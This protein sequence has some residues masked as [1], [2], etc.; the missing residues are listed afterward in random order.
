MVP[1][2]NKAKPVSYPDYFCTVESVKFCKNTLDHPAGKC[3]L[4]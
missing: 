1:A 4:S 2:E 3:I